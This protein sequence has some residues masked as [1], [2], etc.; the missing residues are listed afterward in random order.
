M[1]NPEEVTQE[2]F[3]KMKLHHRK[4]DYTN[5][6]AIEVV[7]LVRKYINPRCPTCVTC[8]SNLR[9]VK[10]ELNTFYLFH[11]ESIEKRLANPSP[12]VK[13]DNQVKLDV[14]DFPVL[15]VDNDGTVIQT[16]PP[17]VKKNFGSAIDK[18]KARNDK[19]TNS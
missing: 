14:E 5:V 9:D 8:T 3:D 1:S 12:L 6:E 10:K 11:K 19:K 18:I 15:E 13:I 4:Y 7:N 16:L 2:E 17:P